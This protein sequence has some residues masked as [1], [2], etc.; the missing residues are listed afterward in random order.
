MK[1]EGRKKPGDRYKVARIG[2]KL[3]Q[4]EVLRA[5]IQLEEI[6]DHA[7]MRRVEKMMVPLSGGH[8][9]KNIVASIQDRLKIFFPTRA[10]PTESCSGRFRY[11]PIICAAE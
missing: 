11:C 9:M 5:G 2:L 10:D 8:G 7:R 1:C 6:V 3:P 4:D